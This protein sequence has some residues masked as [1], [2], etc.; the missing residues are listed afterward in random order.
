MNQ[1]M[2]EENEE[3]GN[4]FQMFC[5]ETTL[6][7]WSYLNKE[8]S[9]TRKVIWIAILLSIL[10]ISSWFI[11]TNVNQVSKTKAKIDTLMTLR[12]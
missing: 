7:G 11:Y 1:V 12:E 3:R 4:S 6:H 5:D 9:R 10:S 8:I 2:K